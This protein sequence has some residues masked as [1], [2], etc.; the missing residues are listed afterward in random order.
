MPVVGG[1]AFNQMRQTG[2][3]VGMG[4][5]FQV[6]GVAGIGKN[7]EVQF[8]SKRQP[9]AKITRFP[10]SMGVSSSKTANSSPPRNW[11]NTLGVTLPGTWKA[12]LSWPLVKRR[13]K[14]IEDA[15]R[16]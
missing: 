2:N 5:I 9:W 8:F 12:P 1:K 7:K 3:V 10:N 14:L 11:S 6:D 15:L 16:P 4:I 13:R